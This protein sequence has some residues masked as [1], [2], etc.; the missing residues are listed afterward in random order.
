MHHWHL[1]E[2]YC[3]CVFFLELTTTNIYKSFKII[4]LLNASIVLIP[5]SIEKLRSLGLV[6]NGILSIS[7]C[8]IKT[9]QYCQNI[10]SPKRG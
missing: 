9:V 10:T 7:V 1:N 6:G 3:G 4:C 5:E 2:C 8:R